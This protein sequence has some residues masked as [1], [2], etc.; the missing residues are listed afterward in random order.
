MTA[1][2]VT[3]RNQNGLHARPAGLLAQTAKLFRSRIRVLRA[4]QEADGKSILSLM[5]LEVT[6]GTE[7]TIQAEGDD[8][9]EA[10]SRLADVVE[11]RF[12][13]ARQGSGDDT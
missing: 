13:E 4:A 7:L 11:S 1:R 5:L 2:T 10:V 9:V 3:I 8:E 12:G 6:P